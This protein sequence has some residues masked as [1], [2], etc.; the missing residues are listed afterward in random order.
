MAYCEVGEAGAVDAW[1][2]TKVKLIWKKLE[3]FNSCNPLY[4]CPL[5]ICMSVETWKDNR[6]LRNFMN[7]LH[8]IN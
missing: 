3:N 7:K 6:K 5:Y 1:I 8:L 4:I 2:K